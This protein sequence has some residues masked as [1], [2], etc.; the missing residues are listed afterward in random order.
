MK[1][2]SDLILNSILNFVN[3]FEIYEQIL[4]VVIFLLMFCFA[5]E[6][7]RSFKTEPKDYKS[8]I[9]SLG[10]FGTFVGIFLGL[11]NFDTKDISGSVPKLLDG[12]KVAFITSILG[13]GISIL[14][15][16]FSSFRKKAKPELSENNSS[17]ILKLIL[18]KISSFESTSKD[19][20]NK[21]SL[22]HESSEKA[23]GEASVNFEKMNESIL[24]KISSFE[25]IFKYTNDKI[26]LIHESSE[27][28]R[29]EASVN[30]EK[31]NESLNK[32]VETLSKG[33]TEEIIQ[34]LERVISDFNQNLTD[35][36]GDNFKQLNEAVKNMIVWQEN[37]KNSIE[38]IEGSLKEALLGI[39][40]TNKYMQELTQ[41]YQNLSQVS[42][43]L[44]STIEVNQNQIRNLEAHLN[45]LKAI[46]DEARVITDSINDFSKSIKG[47]LSN[48]SQGLN[49][50][51]ETLTQQIESSTNN[52][53]RALTSLTD[54]FRQNYEAFLEGVKEL[55]DKK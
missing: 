43:D 36:F 27:K 10:V 24:S 12:L 6:E 17:E 31:M 29:G 11:W 25:S 4:I 33:V 55:M 51:S 41:N 20:N 50:L 30:F 8:E 45:S 18:E 48:Q 47:S 22:I 37:Y 16:V 46:G 19:T 9:I 23:R 53:N 32:A 26:S 54:N 42:R 7:W 15:S 38:Q 14:L 1:E 39:E 13:M 5:R 40:G 49:K 35:Q 44:S 3:Q 28:A 52:L 2:I 21:I 34:T